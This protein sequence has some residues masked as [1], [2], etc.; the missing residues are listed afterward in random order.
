MHL[1]TGSLNTYFCDME[2][3]SRNVL[4]SS[5]EYSAFYQLSQLEASCFSFGTY[6][7]TFLVLCFNRYYRS[8]DSDFTALLVAYHVWP[9]LMEKD[10]VILKGEAVTKRGALVCTLRNILREVIGSKHCFKI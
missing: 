2:I 4:M 3:L 8:F 1:F 7:Q 10:V 6:M 9:A 5:N